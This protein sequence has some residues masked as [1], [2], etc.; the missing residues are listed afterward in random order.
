MT[1][2]FIAIV[3]ISALAFVAGWHLKPD[4]KTKM[5]VLSEKTLPPYMKPCL[6]L[7]GDA[8]FTIEIF[9]DR[10]MHFVCDR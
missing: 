5:F 1:K 9:A 8:T 7:T 3:F 4:R 6:T 10:K 2:H